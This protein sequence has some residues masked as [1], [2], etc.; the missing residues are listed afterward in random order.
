MPS[1]RYVIRVCAR[2]QSSLD[3]IFIVV[4]VNYGCKGKIRDGGN[5]TVFSTWRIASCDCN[6]H[7]QIYQIPVQRYSQCCVII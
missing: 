4:F 1:D 6:M 3:L 7:V 5:K 2:R